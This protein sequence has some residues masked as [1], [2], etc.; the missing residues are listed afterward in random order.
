VGRLF[1]SFDEAWS[2][3]AARDEPVEPFWDT[4]SED[5]DA[6]VDVWLLLPDEAIRDAAAA[7][8]R[9]FAHLDW[10]APLPRHFLHLTVA[11][12]GEHADGAAWRAAEPFEL[13]LGPVT[14]FHE[15]VVA[16][17]H[18][19][20]PRR[21][22]ELVGL[23]D[24]PYLPHLSLGY[25]RKAADPAALREALLP[26]RTRPLGGTRVREV[27]LCR[28]LVGRATLFTPWQVVERVQLGAPR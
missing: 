10:I 23:P 25:F 1:T 24:D 26:E 8:Q 7:A 14:C 19:E 5:D 9:P 16:E 22:R 6:T 15:A 21:L 17:A 20:G 12:P 2:D 13:E 4:L 11:S 27:V 18:G 3:F 28:V